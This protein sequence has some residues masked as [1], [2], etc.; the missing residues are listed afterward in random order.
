[1]ETPKKNAKRLISKFK[2]L[3]PKEFGGMELEL[4]KKC[5]LVCVEQVLGQLPY[6]DEHEDVEWWKEVK[7]EIE[8]L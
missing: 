4:S 2:K 8:K 7:Q 1:M 6:H 5:A 3:V